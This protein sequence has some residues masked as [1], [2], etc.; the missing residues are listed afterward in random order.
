MAKELGKKDQMLN[1]TLMKVITSWTI[2]MGMENLDGQAGIFIKVIIWMM[3]DMVM[4]KCTGQMEA[5]IKGNGQ[6]V[7]ST[8]MVKCIFLMDL[9]RSGFLKIMSLKEDLNNLIQI[10]NLL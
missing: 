9:K 4:E 6:K 5:C 10:K 1:Q 7:F 2:N 8:G 3:K